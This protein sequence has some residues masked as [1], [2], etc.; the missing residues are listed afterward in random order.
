M[1]SDWNLQTF[2]YMLGLGKVA[3]RLH[4]PPPRE[5]GPLTQIMFY[6][7][8]FLLQGS[9][10]IRLNRSFLEVPIFFCGTVSQLR[11][12]GVWNNVGSD[13]QDLTIYIYRCHLLFES[14]YY[15]V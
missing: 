5:A 7:N 11:L 9:K 14:W 3:T 6:N 4:L 15:T 10:I 1:N 13:Y 12:L 2:D 8:S